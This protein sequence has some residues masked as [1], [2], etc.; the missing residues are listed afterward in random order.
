MPAKPSSPAKI[1]PIYVVHGAEAF[2]KRQAIAEILDRLLAGADRAMAL[3]EY[4]GAGSIE[5]ASVLDDLRTL[6]FLSD[7]RVVLVRDA[8]AFITR[9]REGL[10]DY[11]ESPSST[12]V[13]VMEARSFPGNTRLAKRAA[14]VGES[15]KC[16]PIAAR[17]VPSWLS[18]RARDAYGLRIEPQAGLML[19]E[20]VGDDLG[21]LD[22]ELQKLALYVGGRQEIR[23]AD[24]QACVGHSREEQV[25]GIL[26]AISAGDEGRAIALWEQ[27]W[28][29]DRAAQG[30]AIGG[31]AFKV[32][33]LLSAKRAEEAGSPM[34]ELGRMLMIWGDERRVRAELNAFTT[35]QVESMLCR[36]LQADVA[37]KTGQATVQSAIEAFIIES[38]RARRQRRAS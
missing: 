30:R 24:V 10:E 9:Y 6:P 19:I 26:S 3:S 34:G 15:I 36:L 27:V 16:E 38:C 7:R 21:L 23:A 17:N 25:W 35:E 12:G 37:A 28:E 2:L 22:A 4:D 13:L 5:L 31:I 11:F 20:F 14:A 33:Q 29:T 8:D 1:A 18:G 32:R